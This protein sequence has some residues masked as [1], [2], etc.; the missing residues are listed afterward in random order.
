MPETAH[1]VQYCP[2]EAGAAFVRRFV[3]AIR[4][5]RSRPAAAAARDEEMHYAVPSREHTY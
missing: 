1:A 4:L 3:S 5:S 2:D